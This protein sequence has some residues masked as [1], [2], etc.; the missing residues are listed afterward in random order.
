M[1]WAILHFPRSGKR[2]N[3]HDTVK[4]NC[5]ESAFQNNDARAGKIE[6]ILRPSEQTCPYKYKM[7]VQK[8]IKGNFLSHKVREYRAQA[9]E[10]IVKE[11]VWIRN[12]YSIIGNGKAGT[13]QI[14]L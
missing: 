6:G 14:G 13:L 10:D 8:W 2:K 4:N 5:P 3:T 9:Y 7:A 12:E 1:L 11:I